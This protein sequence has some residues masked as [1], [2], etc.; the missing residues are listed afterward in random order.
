MRT[1]PAA[2]RQPTMPRLAFNRKD[3]EWRID[4]PGNVPAAAN[5]ASK[6]FQCGGIVAG[7]RR[8]AAPV[9]AIVVTSPHSSARHRPPA[10]PT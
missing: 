6:R 3:T 2:S 4:W 7:G 5:P 1:Q 10:E 8:R 9:H